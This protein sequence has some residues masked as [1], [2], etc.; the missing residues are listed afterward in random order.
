MRTIL[1]W[2][3]ADPAL[4]CKTFWGALPE[5]AAPGVAEA[6]TLAEWRF[7]MTGMQVETPDT[8]HAFWFGEGED[9]AQVARERAPLWWAKRDETDDAIR[10]RFAATLRQAAAGALV[11]WAE[12]PRGRLALILLA[13]QFPRN[14]YRNAPAAFAHDAAARAWCR[15]GLRRDVHRELRAIERVF[16]YLPLE[17]SEALEDQE[18]SVALF[19]ELAAESEPAAQEVFDGF[20]DYA[21]RHRDVIAR[22]GRFPHRNRILGRASTEEEIVF[23][24]QPGSSF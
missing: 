9:D 6:A 20:L 10:A 15:E 12:T 4:D 3:I 7:R 5:F 1:I 17:H 8:I 21:L 16:F 13:D 18:Q 11:D 24:R 19:R 22:F 23:L 14:M 2:I